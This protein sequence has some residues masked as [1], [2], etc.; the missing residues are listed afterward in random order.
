MLKDMLVSS[1]RAESRSKKSENIIKF[2]RCSLL[3]YSR[4]KVCN[5]S[6][7]SLGTSAVDGCIFFK[8]LNFWCEDTEKVSNGLC[9]LRTDSSHYTFMQLPGFLYPRLCSWAPAMHCSLLCLGTLNLTLILDGR[10]PWVCFFSGPRRTRDRVLLNKIEIEIEWE[11]SGLC[12]QWG[13]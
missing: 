5:R 2:C 13:K 10:N 4:P 12:V 6:A 8:I 1:L 7:T 3:W 11:S 9:P